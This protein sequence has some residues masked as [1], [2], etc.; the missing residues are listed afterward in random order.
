MSLGLLLKSNGVKSCAAAFLL[1][2][3]PA[4]AVTRNASNS[5]QLTAALAAAQPGDAI[6]LAAGEYNGGLYRDGLTSVTI[7]GADGLSPDAVVIRGGVNGLQLS[8]ATDV[9]LERLTFAAQTGNGL[10]IDDGGSFATPSTN[11]T[12]RDITVR[13]MAGTGNNDGI[14]LSGVTGFLI[15]KVRVFNWGAAGSAIDPVGSHHGVIQNSH[16][17]STNLS[18]NGSG[19]R[20]KGGS[21]YIVVRANLM[22]LPA[23]TGRAMQA[24]G[25]TDAEFFRFIDG[26]SNYEAADITFYGNRIVGG[27]SAMNWVNIDGGEFHHNDVRGPGRWAMRILNE[28][29]GSAIIDTR[30][31]VFTDNYV[32][33]DGASWNR[34]VNEGAE[35]DPASFTF[36]HN[37]WLN[38]LNPTPAGSM[39]SLPSLEVG[40]DFGV[41]APWAGGGPM[42]WSFGWGEWIVPLATGGE[43]I[44]VA[45]HEELLYAQPQPGATFDPRLDNP[46]QGDWFTRPAE[47]VETSTA[48]T[49]F[50]LIRAENCS[51]CSLID[52]DYDRSGVVDTGDLAYWAQSYGYAGAAPLAD[53]NGDGVVNAADYTVWRDAYE[54]AT[55]SVAVPEA[56]GGSIGVAAATAVLRRA[57]KG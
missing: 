17:R 32:S 27:A 11:I 44:P 26:D 20:P 50:V 37:K 15:D 56:T 55:G 35:T 43:T 47:A 22:E 48:F 36:A 49:D 42:H 28:N 31:G 34:A 2:A 40:G 10:N 6:V 53:G 23:N 19:I 18:D 13:D 52:G 29:P 51:V 1:V 21:K 5:A 3:I 46:L 16:F 41:P 9:T 57:R 54:A 45:K 7:R 38:R 12:L 4:H 14:K 39:V 30:N 24:G 33:F 8:D 25:S